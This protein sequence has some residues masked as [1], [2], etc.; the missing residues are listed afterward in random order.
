MGEHF[1][2]ASVLR[3]YPVG[4]PSL[5]TGRFPGANPLGEP[6]IMNITSISGVLGWWLLFTLVG[7]VIGS[8]Y[9]DAV[10]KVIN[11]HRPIKGPIP[12]AWLSFQVVILAL[13]ILMILLLLNIPAILLLS[14]L[15]FDQP[16]HG[17]NGDNPI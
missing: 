7:I 5:M 16:W 13:I 11:G 1:N 9:F 6:I 4:V 14:L 17:A 10:A 15:A 12:Q 8:L 3:T 2:L